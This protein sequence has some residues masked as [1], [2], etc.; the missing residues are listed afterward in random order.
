MK[1]LVLVWVIMLCLVPIGASAEGYDQPISSPN[2]IVD[3]N[4]GIEEGIRW[5]LISNQGN[6]LAEGITTPYHDPPTLI[7][8]EGNV[9]GLRENS[10]VNAAWYTF[11]DI[12]WER[13]SHPFENVLDLH[14]VNVLYVDQQDDAWQIVLANVFSGEIL[15]RVPVDIRTAGGWGVSKAE[16]DEDSSA[17][18]ITYLAGDKYEETT[19]IFPAEQTAAKF[20]GYGNDE[21]VS[22]DYYCSK[23]PSRATESF[24]SAADQMQKPGGTHLRDRPSTKSRCE[25][26]E[27]F[28]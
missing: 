10:G 21:G 16:W 11:Y 5:L 2:Y 25:S 4:S 26:S 15:H 7:Y 24:Q 13:V 18:L 12:A 20:K 6:V 14:G 1:R 27:I 28:Y 3:E 19:L 17:W 9:I 8:T 23:Q 22:K